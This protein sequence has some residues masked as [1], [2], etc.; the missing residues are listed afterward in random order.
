MLRNDEFTKSNEEM[1][2]KFAL[3]LMY[4]EASVV[5]LNKHSSDHYLSVVSRG[6]YDDSAIVL[7]R[8]DCFLCHHKVCQ[9]T[10]QG[11][12]ESESLNRKDIC[13][14][15]NILAQS[16]AVWRPLLPCYDSKVHS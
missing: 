13:D 4:L 5:L 6:A 1:V 14:H 7:M 9:S 2:V 3:S 12:V 8:E 11:F 16:P 10:N 15:L